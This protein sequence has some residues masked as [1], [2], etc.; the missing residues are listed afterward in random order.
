MPA[1]LT[2]SESLSGL[3]PD[4]HR[5]PVP[6]GYRQPQCTGGERPRG[7]GGLGVCLLSGLFV[8]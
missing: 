1:S 5:G 6:K 7:L 8:P 2:K 4:R 3:E